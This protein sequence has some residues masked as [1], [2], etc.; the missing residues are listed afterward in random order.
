MPSHSKLWMQVWVKTTN[1]VPCTAYRSSSV[2]TPQQSINVVLIT[3]KE[4]M[5]PAF[6]VSSLSE[7]WECYTMHC[8]SVI[9]GCYLSPVI[10]ENEE[11][12]NGTTFLIIC[13]GLDN[14]WSIW[15]ENLPISYPLFI[16]RSVWKGRTWLEWLA[17]KYFGNSKKSKK[18]T[19]GNRNTK[20][21]SGQFIYFW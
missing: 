8:V 3:F 4:S 11:R 9:T 5:I 15:T 16:C 18:H 10:A 19:N 7:N 14:N 1:A 6:T 2:V 13:K 20:T 17:D 21:Q 12:I